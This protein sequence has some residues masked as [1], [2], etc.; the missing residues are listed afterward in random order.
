MPIFALFSGASGYYLRLMELRDV[1]DEHTG[2]PQRGAAATQALIIVS[3][4]YLLLLLLFSLA[5]KSRYAPPAG[6]ENAFGTNALAYPLVFLLIAL[7]WL[8]ATAL[9]YFDLRSSGTILTSDICFL[10]LSALSAVSS[11]LFA[12]EVYQDPRRRSKLALS[13]IP[14][15]FL[16]YWLVFLYRQNAANPIILSYSYFCLAIISSALGFY[17]TAGFVY[18]KPAQAK[19]VITLL[20]A[21]YFCFTTLADDHPTSIK[22]IMIAIIAASIV[23]STLLIKNLQL[24]R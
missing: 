12:I 16:C 13:V 22:L 6:F 3:V 7:V 1:F 19:A 5:A 4:F 9:H 24:K 10:V 17:F 8:G 18:N 23:Y 20:A 14:T 11:F 21:V 2:L 15:L